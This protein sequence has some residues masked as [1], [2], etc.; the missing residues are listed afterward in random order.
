MPGVPYRDDLT[1][2]QSKVL[3]QAALQVINARTDAAAML[4]RAGVEPPPEDG[5]FGNPCGAT[6]PPPPRN[7]RCGC[8]DYHGDGGPC[9]TQYVDFTGPDFGSGSPKRTCHHLP[10]DHLET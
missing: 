9:S 7:H 2:E 10:S 8:R 6:L 1:A 3:E 5:W 4:T